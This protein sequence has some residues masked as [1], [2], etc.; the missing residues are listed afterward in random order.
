MKKIIFLL[1]ITV[2]TTQLFAQD[3]IYRKNGQVV[4]AKVIEVGSTEIKYKLPDD[5]ESPIYVLEKDRI[6]KIEYQNGK[7]EKLLR[8]LEILNNIPGN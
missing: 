1:S 6:N 4:E 3:K 5:A 2:F 7:V 8:I